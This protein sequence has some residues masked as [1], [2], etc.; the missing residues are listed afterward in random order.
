MQDSHLTTLRSGPELKLS[1][2]LNRLSHPVLLGD[3]LSLTET[4]FVFITDKHERKVLYSFYFDAPQD[5]FPALTLLTSMWIQTLL[6]FHH[7]ACGYRLCS[8]F[9]TL[10]TIQAGK[11]LELLYKLLLCCLGDDR[12]P[13]SAQCGLELAEPCFI[14]ISLPALYTGIEQGI[15][16]EFRV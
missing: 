11:V 9:I 14:R 8:G 15:V 7:M 5:G 2:M 1:Q 12:V 3:I 13:L 4:M 10:P 6:W 16:L